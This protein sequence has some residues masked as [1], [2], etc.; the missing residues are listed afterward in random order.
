MTERLLSRGITSGRA[1]D[2]AD[3]I[4]KRLQTFADQTIPVVEHY[5]SKNKTI[6]VSVLIK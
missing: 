2:N 5:R 1:D 4:K 3:T 6:V